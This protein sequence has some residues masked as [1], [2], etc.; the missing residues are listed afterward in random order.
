MLDGIVI[1][2]CIPLPCSYFPYASFLLLSSPKIFP[3]SVFHLWVSAVS[4][5]AVDGAT[6]TDLCEAL[7]VLPWHF[8]SELSSR[9]G[10]SVFSITCAATAGCQLQE[11][12]DFCGIM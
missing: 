4:L 11:F 8:P 5:D 10:K 7:V 12:L 3:F 1:N 2:Q 9:S 6:V